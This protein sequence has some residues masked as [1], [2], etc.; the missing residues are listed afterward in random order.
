MK[1]VFTSI[2]SV[3][4]MALLESCNS[5]L[6][7]CT[8][9]GDCP[10]KQWCDTDVHVCVAYSRPDAGTTDGGATDGG[11]QTG[12]DGG[13]RDGGSGGQVGD[14]GSPL[15]LQASTGAG[16]L[17]TPDGHS[18]IHGRL[19]AKSESVGPAYSIKGGVNP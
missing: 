18:I 14:G 5:G 3:A 12:A 7:R 11:G 19:G 1:R 16:S 15:R 4:A 17:S 2:L 9:D 10:P 13:I 8:S 6:L